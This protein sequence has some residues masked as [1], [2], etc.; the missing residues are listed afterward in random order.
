MNKR[1]NS[2]SHSLSLIKLLLFYCSVMLPLCSAEIF[3]TNLMTGATMTNENTKPPTKYPEGQF[4]E[5]VRQSQLAMPM[6]TT[7]RKD[8]SGHLEP[9]GPVGWLRTGTQPCKASCLELLRPFVAPLYAW[10][11]ATSRSSCGR[12]VR[13]ANCKTTSR[14]GSRHRPDGRPSRYAHWRA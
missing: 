10:S 12:R 7:S 1:N 8:R 2:R 14:C 3:M 13:A 4:C 5:V 9:F 6:A 11:A